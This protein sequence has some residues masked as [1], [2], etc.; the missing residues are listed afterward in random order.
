M[1]YLLKLKVV[2]YLD[3]PQRWLKCQLTQKPSW[4]KLET[5]AFNSSILE[6]KIYEDK[7]LIF[8]WRRE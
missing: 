4:L 1:I 8:E 5:M 2:P 6:I 7:E 3:L